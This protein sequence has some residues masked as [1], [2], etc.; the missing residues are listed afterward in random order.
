MLLTVIG[1]KCHGRIMFLSKCVMC[2]SRKSKGTNWKFEQRQRL[3]TFIFYAGC[4]GKVDDLVE[5]NSQV[6]IKLKSRKTSHPE[7][8]KAVYY[9]EKKK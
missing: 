9:W 7:L 8:P 4:V 5:K 1:Y 2:D 6:S 3:W